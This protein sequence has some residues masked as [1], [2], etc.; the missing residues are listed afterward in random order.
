MPSDLELRETKEVFLL[1]PDGRWSPHSV[2]YA[3]NEENMM[4]REGNVI[5]SNQRHNIILDSVEDNDIMV[6][7]IK[8][9]QA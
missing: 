5:E 1:T 4:H 8:I 3:E 9:S 7:S 6:S 2:A